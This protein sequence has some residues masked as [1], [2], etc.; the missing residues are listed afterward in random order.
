MKISFGKFWSMAEVTVPDVKGKPLALARQ[1]LEDSKLRVNVAEV[2][3]TDV[4]VGQVVSQD[5][6]GGSKVKEQRTVRKWKCLTSKD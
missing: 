2:Y 1:V 6:E 5:P 4:P 3:D